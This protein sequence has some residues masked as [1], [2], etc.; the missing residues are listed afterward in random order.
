[1]FERE[2]WTL[3]RSL[4]TIGQKAGVPLKKLASLIAKELT[5][6]ALDNGGTVTIEEMADGIV[7]TDNGSG[8]SAD[9]E[10]IAKL[11]SINRPL[12]SSKLIRLP[13]RG[14]LGNGLRVVVG[15]VLASRGTL[16]VENFGRKF[17]LTPKDDGST[18]VETEASDVQI[19]TR[20]TIKLGDSI[21]M[22]DNMLE[23]SELAISM[24]SLGTVFKG[25]TSPWWY[26]EEAFF[27]MCLAARQRPLV[28]LLVLFRSITPAMAKDLAR[29]RLCGEMT[30]DSA[31]NLLISLREV[32]KKPKPTV[33]GKMD[34]CF[35]G[36]G[37]QNISGEIP[38]RSAGI[39]G[40]LPFSIDAYACCNDSDKDFIMF[41]VNRT[42]ITG[43]I[44]ISRHKSN[45]V[46]IFG[47]GLAHA[48]EVGRK[49]V[50][51]YVNL[52]TPYMPVTTDGK[53]PDLTRYLNELQQALKKACSKARRLAE[54]DASGKAISQ[55]N[56]IADNLVDAIDKASGGG[57]YRYSLRQLF[58]AVRPYMLDVLGKE[59]DYNYF[60]QV[61]TEIESEQGADLP[62]IYRDARG[63][64]YHP[65]THE[66][67]ALGTINVEKYKRPE[68]NF[69]SV[70]F[71]EK[72]GFFSL[73][74]DT[75]WPERNDCALLTS[76]GFASRAARDVIDM[77]GDTEEE[78]RFFCIADSDASGSL[79][80]Q[81]LTEAT[82]ARGA[83]N[84]KVINLGLFPWEAVE[85]GL[86]VETFR[87]PEDVKRELPVADFI[88]D[89]DPYWADWLQT[90]RVEL[91][92][93][94]SPEFIRWL[95]RKFEPYAG[96]VIP[97]RETLRETF[98]QQGQQAIEQEL[99]QRILREAG[100]ESQVQE[101]VD[102]MREDSL[103]VDLDQVV[104]EGLEEQPVHRWDNPLGKVA[105]EYAKRTLES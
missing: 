63:I 32:S 97:D 14:A 103:T 16:E 12:I 5:D 30:R 22:A 75:G 23:W 18:D 45:Q 50:T 53:E 36:F 67:I 34:D 35:P 39:S 72:Q 20:I 91:N 56:V 38:I 11:F 41:M 70:L 62:G 31:R 69:R 17:T 60:A 65:H 4:S 19:G 89:H 28:D 15:G 86:Q 13:M 81:T 46:A 61:I 3:L 29:E 58:Y 73:L 6:N 2:D 44:K 66:E 90:R 94:T 10:Y 84:V 104:R 71:A 92:A 96:K 1:M 48:F 21:P 54:K 76:K 40:Y 95:D 78:I 105:G 55:R 9:P 27:E 37:Y 26:E 57:L 80:Y 93:M 83:R 7:I 102:A 79:I 33:L 100:F 42:P 49:S 64:L 98:V 43:D 52:M 8:I 51:I 101:A 68:W 82:K 25:K 99:M 87:K 59:P 88:K 24:A 47:C 74:V 85:M 77:I